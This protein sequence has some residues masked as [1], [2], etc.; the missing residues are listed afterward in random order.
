[1][2]CKSFLI[3]LCF[4]VSL[5]SSLG[6][7]ATFIPLT[8]Q[9]E[10]GS[11][12]VSKVKNIILNGATLTNLSNGVALIRL[13]TFPAVT[14][15]T[16]TFSSLPSN[17]SGASIAINWQLGNKQTITLAH[18]VTNVTFT[19]PTGPAS[20]VLQIK[21]DATGSRIITGW[22]VAVKWAGATA[23]TLTAAPNSIDAIACIYDGA[24]YMCQS[25][26]NFL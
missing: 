1:M 12:S 23:P 18:N 10:D 26:L 4:V 6:A 3:W 2:S 22:P 25:S 24:I 5:F 14:S 17:T 13:G 21:Q 19:A 9:E 8:V 15:Q 16:Y 20:L 11:P 7:Q